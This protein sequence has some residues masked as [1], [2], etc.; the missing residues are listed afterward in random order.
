MIVL[1]VAVV[2]IVA[3]LAI[4]RT[5]EA[6][7][8]ADID[9]ELEVVPDNIDAQSADSVR[10]QLGPADADD[11]RVAVIRIGPQGTVIL[12]LQS[13]PADAL[14]P[15]P[16]IEGVTAPSGPMTVSS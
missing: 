3:A 2:G 8:L 4:V 11:R 16:D 7:L 13:G 10:R 9:E 5:L 1:L 15:L 6:R 14:D 12:A